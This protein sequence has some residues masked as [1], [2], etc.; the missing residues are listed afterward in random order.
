MSKYTDR[1]KKV[2]YHSMRVYLNDNQQSW[3]S[4]LK[5]NVKAMGFDSMSEYVTD[6]IEK[7]LK[8]RAIINKNGV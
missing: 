4:L 1:A 2:Q 8:R 5:S 6:L 7:D 3:K